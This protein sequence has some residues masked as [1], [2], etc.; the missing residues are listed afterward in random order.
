MTLTIKR[1]PRLAS[2][3]LWVLASYA[4][5]DLY[6]AKYTAV[7]ETASLTTEL[8]H[9]IYALGAAI[10][11]GVAVYGLANR[12]SYGRWLGVVSFVLDVLIPSVPYDLYSFLFVLVS[13]SRFGALFNTVWSILDLA[14]AA[15]LAFSPQ[16]SDYLREV[17][18][19]V[20]EPDE[21]LS[22][23]DLFEDSIDD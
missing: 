4:I 7:Y 16:V 20:Y 14:A 22:L 5:N 2:F 1:R 19:P 17:D 18:G 10:L 8:F 23:G 6:L 21:G 13:D 15:Y 9:T 11:T 12:K 3:L